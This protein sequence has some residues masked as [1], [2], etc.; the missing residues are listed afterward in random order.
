[1]HSALLIISDANV[2]I[3][4]QT[5]KFWTSEYEEMPAFPLLSRDKIQPQ[6]K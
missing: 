3:S 5:T 2:G 4:R 1:M 6:V